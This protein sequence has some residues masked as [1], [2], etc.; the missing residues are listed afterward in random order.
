MK[1]TDRGNSN[2]SRL[3]TH[4]DQRSP[5]GPKHLQPREGLL[6]EYQTLILMDRQEVEMTFMN[7]IKSLLRRE[8]NGGK[9]SFQPGRYNR[10]KCSREAL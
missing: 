8:I 3:S 4:S 9:S 7:V 1:S 10:T 5:R 2:K 6:L